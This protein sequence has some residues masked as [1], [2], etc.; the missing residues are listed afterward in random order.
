MAETL[1]L[2]DVREHL[3]KPDQIP[4]NA[5]LIVRALS[6]A[7]GHDRERVQDLVLRALEHRAAFGAAG[8]VLDGLVRE[9]GL[10]PYLVPERLGVADAIAYEYHRP[11]NFADDLIFHRVQADVYR[12]LLDGDNIILSAPTSFGKSLIIDAM[13]ASGTCAEPQNCA[14]LPGLRT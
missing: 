8:V 13:I 3:R 5:F 4:E 1:T 12:Y 9:L 14:S 6:A 2:K 11:D 7:V 10:F